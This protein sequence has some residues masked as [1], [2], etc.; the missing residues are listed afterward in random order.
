MSSLIQLVKADPNYKQF[1]RIVEHAVSRLNFEA[2][3]T[4]IK[5]LHGGRRSRSMYGDRRYSPKYIIESSAQD[6][7][8]RARLVEIRINYD[9]Q[10]STIR[11]AVA[12]MKRHVTTEYDDDLREYSTAQVRRDFADR[13]V[14]QAHRILA[15]GQNVI[16][17]VDT[18]I[19]DIDQANHTIRHVIECLK[20]VS[21]K[22]KTI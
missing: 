16:D 1:Q 8:V 15:D 7:S 9:R 11:E 4:E 13:V 12:A 17:I 3:E 20:L 19:K 22:G 18:V 21:D 2:V 14:K 5:A 10:L 6:L